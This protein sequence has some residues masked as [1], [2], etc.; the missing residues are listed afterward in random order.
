MLVV[1]DQLKREVAF[2]TFPKRIVSLV[3]SITELLFD[4][5][6]NDEVVGITKFCVHPKSWYQTKTKVGGTK[7]INAD[8]IASLN[9]DLIIANKEENLKE[10]VEQLKSVAPVF[11]TDV[12]NLND[13]LTMIESI[14]LITNSNN[15]AQSI[16][17]NIKNEFERIKLPQNKLR[18]CYLIWK[19]PYMSIG[20]DTFINDMLQH[21]G[22]INVFADDKRYPEIIIS[23]LVSLNCQVILLSSE[24]YP[25]KQKNVDELQL[26]LP[27]TKIILVDGEMFSW[28][29]SRLQHAAK[30]FSNLI[31]SV[32]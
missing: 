32:L 7:N 20:G 26:L 3:P 10:Q 25:F 30:Y 6:L 18:V 23:Q 2:Y 21:C 5:N 13:A 15:E 19:E 22:F 1:T 31:K 28:Y 16:T 8:V 11:I 14:G 29:G 4:L 17:Q 24:P 12:C 9:A 27:A